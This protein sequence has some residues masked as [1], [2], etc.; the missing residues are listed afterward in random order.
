MAVYT[1]DYEE[2]VDAII[3]KCA[4]CPAV[5]VGPDLVVP[6]VY[7]T[8]NAMW[9]TGSTGCLIS[10]KLVEELGL[11]SIDRAEVSQATVSEEADVYL[12]HV[13]LP[14]G[15]VVLNVEALGM[16]GND[17]DFVIGMDIISQCDFAF[18]NKDEQSVFSFRRPAKEH[19]RFEP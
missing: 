17:Y 9:D 4:I 16:P 13:G 2:I 6:K 10:Q 15:Q 7:Y 12:V 18:T 5:E 19:I 8:D 1:R 11:E 14:N 3:T